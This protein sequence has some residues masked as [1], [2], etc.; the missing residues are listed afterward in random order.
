[1]DSLVTHPD[2]NS[3]VVLGVKISND[4]LSTV[5]DVIR[6]LP[7]D[8]INQIKSGLIL[9]DSSSRIWRSRTEGSNLSW[10][11]DKRSCKPCTIDLVSDMS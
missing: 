1:L 9:F 10:T 3:P 11:C 2:P 5:V 4:S 6:S 8:Q 7:P